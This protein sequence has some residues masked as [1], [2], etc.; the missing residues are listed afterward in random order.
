MSQL[1]RDTES[2]FDENKHLRTE[3][4]SLRAEIANL[5]TLLLAHENCPVTQAMHQGIY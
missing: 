2:V 3:I 5:K 4:V 1:K